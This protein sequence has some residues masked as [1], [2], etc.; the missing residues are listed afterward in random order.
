LQD[1]PLGFDFVRNGIGSIWSQWV[2][3]WHVG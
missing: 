3:E 2:I 1:K